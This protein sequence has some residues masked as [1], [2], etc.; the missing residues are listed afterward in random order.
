[1]HYSTFQNTGSSVITPGRTSAVR[2]AERWTGC[3]EGLWSIL[4]RYSRPDW[5]P[6]C[7]TC[8]DRRLSWM[9]SRGPSN[10][11]YCVEDLTD[12]GLAFDQALCVSA[13]YDFFLSLTDLQSKPVQ[14][15]KHPESYFRKQNASFLPAQ[16][17]DDSRRHKSRA[18]PNVYYCWK[19]RTER[20]KKAFQRE[21]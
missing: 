17:T 3:P 11:C 10:P 21:T 20:F 16:P 5:V 12:T 1:M 18:A 15:K 2:V 6:M 19:I 13:T 8:S 7:A 4:W 14:Q 9:V